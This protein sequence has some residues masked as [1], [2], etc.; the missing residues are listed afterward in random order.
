MTIY[1]T[2]TELSQKRFSFFFKL[3][4]AVEHLVFQ[5]H[6]ASVSRSSTKLSLHGSRRKTSGC[7]V[8][9]SSSSNSS[10]G[11]KKEQELGRRRRRV[12]NVI[13]Q[14]RSVGPP[15]CLPRRCYRF[16]LRLSDVRAPASSCAQN[17]PPSPQ[18]SRCLEVTGSPPPHRSRRRQNTDLVHVRRSVLGDLTCFPAVPQIPLSSLCM[19]DGVTA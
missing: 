1:T 7:A 10:S 6:L 4:W 8:D 9:I 15:R 12:V 5:S 2:S 14:T 17:P 19:C 11:E 16:S 3:V 18:S 13:G